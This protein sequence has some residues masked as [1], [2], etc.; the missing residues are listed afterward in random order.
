MLPTPEQTKSASGFMNR[1]AIGLLLLL[2]VISLPAIYS[3]SRSWMQAFQEAEQSSRSTARILG[4]SVTNTMEKIDYAL[5]V[6]A[7][8]VLQQQQTGGSS[9]KLLQ[10]VERQHRQIPE[11]EDLM[12]TD[13]RGTVL[14]GSGHQLSRPVSLADRDYFSYLRD[15]PDAGL[16][17]SKRIVSKISGKWVI[18]CARRINLSGKRFGGVVFGVLPL[19]QFYDLFSQASLGK[20]G[21]VA[22]RS[23]DMN[24]I[25][26]YAAQKDAEMTQNISSL[27][28]S[29]EWQQKLAQGHT[30]SGNYVAESATD[31]VKR[32][33][34]YILLQPYPLYLNVG[35]AADDYMQHWRKDLFVTI[36]ALA[37][38][39]VGVL[40]LIRQMYHYKRQTELEQMVSERTSVLS[41]T[42]H[43][44]ARNELRLQALLDISHYQATDAQALLD[45]ALEKVIQIT[46]SQIGYI[47]HYH[48][49]RQEFVLNSWSKE[50][51]SACTVANPAT[52]YRLDKT[53]FWGEAVRQRKAIVTN[54][55]DAPDELKKGYPEGHVHMSRFLTVP[56]FEADQQIVAVVGVANKEQP[57]TDQDM[58]QLE[59]MMSEVWRIVKRLEL[60]KRLVIA[61][62]EWQAT[63]DAISDSVSLIGLDQRIIRTNL[64]STRFFNRDFKQIIGQHCWELVHG[65]DHPIDGCPMLRACK[66]HK[67]ECQL[68]FEH[69]RWLQV[70]VDPL[71]NEQGELTGAVHIVHDDTERSLSEQAVLD[72]QKRFKKF[73][74]LAPIP[75]CYVD[76]TGKAEMINKRF[77]E[78]FGYTIQD[79]PDFQ[80]WWIK[81]YPDKDYRAVVQAQWDCA[82]TAAKET[83]TDICP[84]ENTVTCLDNSMR[85]ILASGTLIGDSYLIILVDIT[86]R[87]QTEE[88]LREIQAQLLQNEKMASIGQLSAGIAH[89]INNPMGF[90]NSNLGT[91]EK[92][93]DKFDRYIGTLEPLVQA[94]ADEQHWQAVQALRKE[95]KLDYVLRDIHQLLEES[96]DGASRV[97]RIVQD[98]KTFSR[99]DTAQIARAE[100]HQCIDSTINII[101]NQIKYVAELHKEYGDLPKV[102]CNVQQINQ[103]FMNLLVNACHAIQGKELDTLGTITVRTWSDADTAY[104]AVS[105]TGCGIS[106]EVQRRI[107]EP[108]YTTKEV[109]KG[110]GLGLSISHEIIKKHGGELTV[111]SEVGKGTTFTIQLPL[112]AKNSNAE[113]EERRKDAEKGR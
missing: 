23:A 87:K 70:T 83:N 9:L 54:D 14:M 39:W 105:D 31:G 1:M 49:D 37:A 17:L 8:E 34:S 79:V 110:T 86:E 82:V 66:S 22:L 44:L 52:T 45:F 25:L 59:L 76:S 103:V 53:G 47:Y 11:L 102:P 69:G 30:V 112:E 60:E 100:L 20:N 10:F 2:V 96:A 43:E 51:M 4:Q 65:T 29:P 27:R 24:L 7:E 91:L 63:F 57:Y 16:V 88:H 73:F 40:L 92:Y 81:A 64:A 95:L 90:I 71:L 109:G 42:S 84:I 74:D 48:E 28:I 33:F 12:M 56:V 13:A 85:T 3:V 78:L 97:M 46:G 32:N 99:S 104:I 108:F 77:T 19:Q 67:T 15:N 61:G 35:L 98:L 107:F 94:C 36:L 101:W 89:E 21:T 75:L 6:M 58:Q 18:S 62:H 41:E 68:V 26:R 50:V 72:G 113:Q 55:F 111:A 80:Q 5:Q 106:K 38:C 93:V